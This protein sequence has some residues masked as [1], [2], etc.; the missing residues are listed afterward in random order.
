MRTTYLA[1]KPTAAHNNLTTD[2]PFQ[3]YSSSRPNIFTKIPPINKNTNKGILY[4][5]SSS[6]PAPQLSVREGKKPESIPSDLPHMPSPPTHEP[7]SPIK[8]PRIAIKEQQ[9]T[10]PSTASTPETNPFS[11]FA[12]A[13]GSKSASSAPF[14]F[15][16]PTKVKT[17]RVET[18]P[19]SDTT[20]S[21]AISGFS[22]GTSAPSTTSIPENERIKETER[23]PL[24]E[25][26][27]KSLN[28]ALSAKAEI[29]NSGDEKRFQFEASITP[30]KFSIASDSTAPSALHFQL[31]PPDE[32]DPVMLHTPIQS[33]EKVERA[34][35]SSTTTVNGGWD[36]VDIP[37]HVITSLPDD[38]DHYGHA[39]VTPNS[40][41]YA[42]YLPARQ[43]HGLITPPETP[44][45]MMGVLSKVKSDADYVRDEERRGA[46]SPIPK[47]SRKPL[48][49]LPAPMVEDRE[50]EK[51]NGCATYEKN[52]VQ[53]VGDCER[54][55]QYEEEH[56]MK[57]G[58]LQRFGLRKLKEMVGR[59]VKAV[60]GR[61]SKKEEPPISRDEVVQ[62]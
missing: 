28:V 59:K 2:D 10:G 7:C 20:S 40:T 34:H 13:F 44:E 49:Q 53:G 3:E 22:F 46:G 11:K 36:S 61:I 50:P 43:R 14:Q 8:G 18:L 57:S 52:V 33:T 30:K 41:R 37:A 35:I 4:G 32:H 31:T 38:E 48:P 9:E 16:T 54:A 25:K 23:I 39:N 17:I 24:K 45:N 42:T 51:N 26:A 15:E 1:L 21:A 19:F 29:S 47:V 56:E 62:E 12:F 55:E 5:N 60:R 6:A 27:A 58:Y